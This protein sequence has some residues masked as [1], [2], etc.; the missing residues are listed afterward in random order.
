MSSVNLGTYFFE[1]LLPGWVE[2][3]DLGGNDDTVGDGPFDDNRSDF[4]I[5]M[6]N[7]A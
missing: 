3:P 2:G 6:V 5:P 4:S 1:D 7:G